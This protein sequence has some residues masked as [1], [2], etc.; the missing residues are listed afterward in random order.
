M[1]TIMIQISIKFPYSPL[2]LF[3][4]SATDTMRTHPFTFG[5]G[6][7]YTN[8][9]THVVYDLKIIV[10]YLVLYF[11]LSF[12]CGRTRRSFMHTNSF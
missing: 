8:I 12:I 2:T 4:E 6:H 1:S 10:L 5:N 9:H 11:V 7:F 3:M